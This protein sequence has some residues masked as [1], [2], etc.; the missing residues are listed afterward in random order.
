MFM[1]PNARISV[2]GGNQ[3]AAVLGQV[4]NLNEDQMQGIRVCRCLLSSHAHA[5]RLHTRRTSTTTRARA[6]TR[7]P[8]CGTTVSSPLRYACLSAPRFCASTHTTGH[9]AD[10]GP[11]LRCRVQRAEEHYEVRSF[12]DVSTLRTNN[13][14][15][16]SPP[17]FPTTT[18]LVFV[19]SVINSSRRR[20]LACVTHTP[21]KSVAGVGKRPLFS[22]ASVL[23]RILC[24]YFLLG[25]I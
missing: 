1:W 6:T 3:A 15:H 12:Q 14:K 8:G 19:C 4:G 5:C 21:E 23:F 10:S 9:E 18:P 24:P 13:E 7:A 2:M 22:C 16:P 11:C 20:L 17:S 25:P